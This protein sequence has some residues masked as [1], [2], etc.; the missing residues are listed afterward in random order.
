[1][2]TVLDPIVGNAEAATQQ[3]A[4]DDW[5]AAELERRRQQPQT[6]T[7]HAQVM[8]EMRALIAAKTTQPQ[9]AHV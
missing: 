9:P 3:Q 7:P 4:H 8:A 6:L 2:N 5:I 1:M